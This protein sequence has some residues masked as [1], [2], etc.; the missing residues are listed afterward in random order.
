MSGKIVQFPKRRARKVIEAKKR[1][2][3]Q[4]LV[5]LSLVSLVLV[6]IFANEQ[7]LK[8]QRPLYIVSDNS[9]SQSIQAL[10]RA[11]AS[12]R[13]F[14]P[15][16]DLE[17]EQQLA[18]KLG[19]EAKPTELAMAEERAPASF[20]RQASILDQVRFGALA[21]KYRLAIKNI[22]GE[23]RVESIEYIDSMESGDRPQMLDRTQFLRDYSRIFAVNFVRPAYSRLEGTTEVYTLEDSSR[24]EVGEALVT[25]DDEGRFL[26]L[27]FATSGSA[28]K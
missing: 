12:A 22:E 21:G 19:H 11:I 4:A 25:V 17:W 8:D 27:R 16:R 24:R 14:N 20:G 6:A 9:S 5:A 2:S 7:V 18:K 1:E 26:S 3:R 28:V 13:P 23:E 10:N 15:L